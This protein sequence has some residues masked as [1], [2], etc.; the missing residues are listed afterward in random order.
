M[1]HQWRSGLEGGRNLNR[2][3]EGDI[4]LPNK[5]IKVNHWKY[6]KLGGGMVRNLVRT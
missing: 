5:T 6:K 2:E 3:G 1:E 4:S